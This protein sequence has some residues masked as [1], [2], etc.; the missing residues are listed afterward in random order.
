[1]ALLKYFKVKRSPL[2]DPDG[3]LSAHIST[4]CIKGANEE[5]AL[6]LNDDHSN[7]TGKRSPGK[8]LSLV[9]MLQS[10]G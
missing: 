6:I 8:R 7:T 1:M 2:P 3:P 9:G 10:T 4:E 5:V